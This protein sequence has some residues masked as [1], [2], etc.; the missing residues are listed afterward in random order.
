[1]QEYIGKVNVPR[2]EY[3]TYITDITLQLTFITL[4]IDL[5]PTNTFLKDS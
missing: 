5:H 4:N 1:M 3:F 2:T